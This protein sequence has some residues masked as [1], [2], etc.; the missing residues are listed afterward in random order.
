[1]PRNPYAAALC[2]VLGL[3]LI[4]CSK[5]GVDGATPA[6]AQSQAQGS[7]GPAGAGAR[8]GGRR[9]AG[10]PVPVLMAKVQSKT[11]PVTIPAVGTAEASTTVQIRAQVT[12]QLSEVQFSEGQDVRKGQLLFL[13]DPRP[14]QAA[15]AQ[16][17][18]VLAR[19]TAT[20]NNAARQRA[21]YEDLYKRQLISRDQYETQMAAAES[22]EATLAADRAA[23]DNAK[24]NLSYTRIS[25]PISG[26]TGTLGVHQGD[27]VRANDAN[28][29]IVINQ[30]SPIYVTFSVPG[31]YL[32]DIRRFQAQ[33]PLEVLAQGQAPLAPGAQAPPPQILQP[34]T[35]QQVAPGQGATAPVAPGLVEHGRVSFI[36]N[37]VDP[38]TGTIK[39]KG[40]FQNADQGLWPGLFVQVTL[41]LTSD[42]NA[43]VVPASAVQPSASGQY[44]YVV[45]PDRTAEVRPVTVARQQGEEVVIAK[46][47]AAGE[48]VVTEGQLRLTPGA[49]VT[50]AN[51][52][53]GPGGGAPG[54]RGGR[55]GDGGS[56]SGGGQGRGGE[57]RGRRNSQ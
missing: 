50:E 43:I 19:D 15:L 1:M 7:G 36:D 27:L 51:R 48:D 54:G 3:S 17:E 55:R 35:Q 52:N 18:A 4:S 6:S 33:K 9:G 16:A 53:G 39:L 45:K 5:D 14:F 56:G 57:G 46:G 26:R 13:I 34:S 25:A 31:R 24:L 8:G 30:V 20:S 22:L 2:V 47:L 37:T 40:T 38:Q 21:N 11:V 32:G 28:P 10:G 44:V 12:G 49:Q 41:S 42:Q 23:V 29:M